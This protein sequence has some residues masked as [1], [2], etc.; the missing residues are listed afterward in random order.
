MVTCREEGVAG[1]EGMRDEEA[2][3]PLYPLPVKKNEEE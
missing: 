3:E 2:V 1:P